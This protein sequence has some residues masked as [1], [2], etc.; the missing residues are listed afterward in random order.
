M[1]CKASVRESRCFWRKV[2]MDRAGF[3]SE[4]EITG[5][6]GDKLVAIMSYTDVYMCCRC[7]AH[8]CRCECLNSRH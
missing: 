1:L 7:M 6:I 8:S 5:C 4:V 2:W 3:Y